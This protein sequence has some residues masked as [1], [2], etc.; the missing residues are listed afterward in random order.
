MSEIVESINRFL[1]GTNL[2]KGVRTRLT[3]A[4]D[5]IVALRNRLIEAEISYWMPVTQSL[6]EAAAP[7]IKVGD[8]ILGSNDGDPPVICR[9][10]WVDETDDLWEWKDECGNTVIITD[11]M[12]VPKPPKS[13]N[14][15][16]GRRLCNNCTSHFR[17]NN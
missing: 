7:Y 6:L 15:L 16:N 13:R 14:N 1:A 17:K 10:T 5:E 4:R 9:K 2:S 3:R 12:P 8:R 11:W